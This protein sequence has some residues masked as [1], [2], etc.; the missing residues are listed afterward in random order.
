MRRRGSPGRVRETWRLLSPDASTQAHRP[1]ASRGPSIG[2][3]ST[4]TVVEDADS[5]A[6][7]SVEEGHQA[8]PR[9]VPPGAADTPGRDR[10]VSDRE[11]QQSGHV[12]PHDLGNVLVREVRE[13]IDEADRVRHAR[14]VRIVEAEDDMVRADQLHQLRRIRLVERVHTDIALEDGSR[15]FASALASI[16]FSGRS[17]TSG[18]SGGIVWGMSRRLIVRRRSDD[19]GRALQR[20]VRRGGAESV[21]RVVRCRRAMV[22]LASAGGNTVEVITRLVQASPVGCVR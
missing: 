7:G 1:D 13:V 14:W 3:W 11:V 20:V 18:W 5:Q 21:V 6:P 10:V 9:E 22:V 16:L 19:E 17:T 8:A 2:R 12:A 15:I 4:W